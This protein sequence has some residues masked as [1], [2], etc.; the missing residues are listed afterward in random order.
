MRGDSRQ[1]RAIDSQDGISDD[2]TSVEESGG[3]KDCSSTDSVSSADAVSTEDAGSVGNYIAGKE[4]VSGG[5]M[6]P[7]LQSSPQ[8]SFLLCG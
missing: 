5:N 3:I 6:R 1:G 4:S 7:V 8:K 2:A